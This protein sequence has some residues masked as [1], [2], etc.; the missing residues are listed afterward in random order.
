MAL[1]GLGPIGCEPSRVKA[2]RMAG[3]QGCA[4]NVNQIVGLY[5]Q[6][7]PPIVDDLNKN[8]PDAK[9]IF[10][11]TTHTSP[12]YNAAKI[13][14]KTCHEIYTSLKFFPITMKHIFRKIL[15]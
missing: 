1:Y 4:E 10:I 2:L 9:F 7:L 11:N 3:K 14:N 8:L 5:N 6:R 13:G 12:V 15:M